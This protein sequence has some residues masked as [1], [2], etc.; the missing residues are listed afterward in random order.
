MIRSHKEIVVQ[1]DD[2]YHYVVVSLKK[3]SSS[4]CLTLGN[5]QQHYQDI[6]DFTS[7]INYVDIVLVVR[8]LSSAIFCTLTSALPH[9]KDGK[10]RRCPVYIKFEG[11]KIK[12]KCEKGKKIKRKCEKKEK[13]KKKKSIV[14]ELFFICF[15]FISLIFV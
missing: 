10:P 2:L 12:R 6:L 13:V 14:N 8:Y 3:Q 5:V 11:K 9:S 1:V 4:T 7:S 15:K